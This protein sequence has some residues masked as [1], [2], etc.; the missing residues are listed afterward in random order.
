M[1]KETPKA[2]TEPMTD[3]FAIEDIPGYGVK[4]GATFP[5]ET[6][7]V[8]DAVAAGKVRLAKKSDKKAAPAD[9]KASS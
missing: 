3:V 1:A 7:F 2:P 5:M 4:A 6:R 8:R 9:E